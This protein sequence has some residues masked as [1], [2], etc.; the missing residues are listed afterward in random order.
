MY[1]FHIFE[2]HG[3]QAQILQKQTIYLW[4]FISI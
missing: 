4:V 3:K 2:L 1:M